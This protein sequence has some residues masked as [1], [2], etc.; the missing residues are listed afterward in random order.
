MVLMSK[1]TP[2]CEVISQNISKSMDNKISLI[3]RIGIR[4]HL[5]GCKFCRRFEKQL[6]IMQKMIQ[7]QANGLN[8]IP[9]GPKLSDE[10]RQKM[11]QKIIQNNLS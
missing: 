8:E 7:N 6:F 11:K 2:A 10:S 3:D 9:D 5:L 4:V 1:M